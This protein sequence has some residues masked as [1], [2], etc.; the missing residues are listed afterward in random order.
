M[1][2][3]LT[4]MPGGDLAFA[5][6]E[7]LRG[8]EGKG[9]VDWSKFGNE[10]GLKFYAASMALGLQDLHDA[11]FVYR[12]LK[13]ANVLLDDKGNVRI[14]DMGLTADIS[15][16]PIKHKA[17]SPGYWAPEQVKGE[18]YTTAPDWWSL[19]VTIYA[20]ATDK[21]LFHSEEET[22]SKMVKDHDWTKSPCIT[23]DALKDCLQQLCLPSQTDRINSLDKLKA[24]AWFA[25]FSWNAVIDGTMPAPITPNVNKLNCP[26]EKD[27]GDF[28]KIGADTPWGDSD[29]KQDWVATW[30]FTNPELWNQEMG[31]AFAAKKKGGGGGGGGG[32]C[33]TIV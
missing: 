19:G 28:G 29:E 21:K 26:S 16:G 13:P 8:G 15:G 4:L 18:P 2:L 9:D 23:S 20:L 33:C 12:D 31:I 7:Y 27:I 24:H 1:C 14:S 17:G 32:G 25:G 10:E 6:S 5:I 22:C 11:G 30:N 3:V